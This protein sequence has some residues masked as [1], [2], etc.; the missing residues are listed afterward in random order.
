MRETI[1]TDNLL[2]FTGKCY[3]FL[4]YITE[5]INFIEYKCDNHKNNKNARYNIHRSSK[6]VFFFSR[7]NY[8]I[9]SSSVTIVSLIENMAL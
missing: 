3:S 5:S 2:P 4:N 9:C 8:C 1:V 6:L 7:Q